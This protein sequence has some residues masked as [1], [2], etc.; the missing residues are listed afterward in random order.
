MAGNRIRFFCDEAGNKIKV[1]K[2]NTDPEVLEQVM[3]EKSR[4]ADIKDKGRFVE[5]TPKA[6]KF[7]NAC[8]N[9]AIF[10]M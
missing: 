8:A 5:F 6:G 7:L 3:S 4:F 10:N 2:V 1:D 9:F